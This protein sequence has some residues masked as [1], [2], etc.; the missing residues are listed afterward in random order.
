MIRKP[1]WT[2]ILLLAMIVASVSA[3]NSQ[4]LYNMNLPQNHLMN[5]ALKP[6]NSLYIGL[7]VISGISLNIDNNIVNFSDVFMKGVKGDSVTS[8]LH[9]G[10]NI[11]NFL[12]KIKDISTIEPQMTV[13]LFGLGY[14]IGR[15]GYV[16]LDIN[17][18]VEGNIILPEDLFSLVLK[19]N[20]QFIGGK[21][22]LSALRGDLKYYRE[23]GLGF[24]K[25]IT[26]KFRIGIKGKLLYGIAALS[27][28]NRL[29]EISSTNDY[30]QKLNADIT[31]NVSGPVKFNINSDHTLRSVVI[32]KNRF[33]ESGGLT[34]FLSGKN[35]RGLGIDF[36]AT[37]DIT[38]KL[39]VS[40][41]LTDIGF[42]K[43]EKDVTNLSVKSR[44]EF[45]GLNVVDVI[46]GTETFE[47]LGQE[48]VDSLNRAFSFATTKVHFTDNLQYGLSF[49]GT[50]SFTKNISLGLL[51]YR[52]YLNKQ[53]HKSL[54]FS[55]NVNL[56]NK[57][58]SSLSYTVASNKY[59]NLGAG[60]AFRTGIFQFYLLSDRIPVMWDKIKIDPD[61]SFI[62]PSR[63]NTINLRL[64]INLV[65][66]DSERKVDKPMLMVE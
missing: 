35:N 37:Y 3:Q 21:I 13:Q 40:A 42:I 23:I 36:G 62:L 52:R 27:I 8:I 28:D 1:S 6:S 60:I 66:G 25:N 33:K 30:L 26:K 49:G 45:G 22:N 16:F 59:N 64:G 43:W 44:F 24:S 34:D 14:S 38:R 31:V 47:E 39:M 15:N 51:S 32:D 41:A 53:L 5:P 2:L 54:T 61:N 63:W 11:D 7:P 17:D 46:N 55:A 20:K 4:V 19:G 48:M 65:F 29:F 10:F 56:S 50:Y 18:R 57:F 12:A 58:S 9:R